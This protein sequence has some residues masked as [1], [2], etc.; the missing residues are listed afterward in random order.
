MLPR[1]AE[2]GLPTLCSQEGTFQEIVDLGRNLPGPEEDVVNTGMNTLGGH[3][4][5][6]IVSGSPGRAEGNRKRKV[7]QEFPV[8]PLEARGC[9]A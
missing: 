9:T 5:G 2:S 6:T 4:Q 3:N 8:T 7:H 1:Q